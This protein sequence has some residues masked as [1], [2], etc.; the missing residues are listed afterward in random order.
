MAKRVT[1]VV[2]LILVAV[3][4]QSFFIFEPQVNAKGEKVV[5]W[6]EFLKIIKWST[7]K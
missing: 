6:S 3:N 4:M 2:T 1:F 5:N 7:T